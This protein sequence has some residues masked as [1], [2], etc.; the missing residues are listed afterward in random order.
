M[1]QE[2]RG[3]I[4]LKNGLILYT[5][6]LI[7]IKYKS[8]KDT[9]EQICIGRIKEAT[10]VFIR[11]DTSKKYIASEKTIYAWDLIDIEKVSDEDEKNN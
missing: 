4:L 11:L 2:V 1:I 5:G 3:E 9:D 7:E 10:E 8:D 6:D